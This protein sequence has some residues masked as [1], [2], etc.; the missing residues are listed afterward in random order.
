MC[1]TVSHCHMTTH[2]INP[3]SADFPSSSLTR[4]DTDYIITVTVTN[5]ARLSSSSSIKIT[6]DLTP[7]VPG[8]VL[9]GNPGQPELDY[10]LSDSVTIRWSGF[11]DPETAIVFYQYAIATECLNV[12][13]FSY[14]ILTGSPVQQTIDTLVSWTAP[15]SGTYYTTV[16][17]YNGA[18]EQ[19]VPPACSDGIT[20]DEEPPVFDGVVIPGARVKPGLV[21]NGGNVWLVNERRER[22]RVVSPFTE[23]VTRSRNITT[24]EL[25][26]LPILTN[27]YD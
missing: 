26:T 3:T 22:A 14:P 4:H 21:S 20:I 6:V 18:F 24:Q 9:E 5:H 2:N 8:V 25:M 15:S 12:S 7:P 1:D 27:R 16:V 23:C 13:L 10:Q 11:F 19:S 17:G